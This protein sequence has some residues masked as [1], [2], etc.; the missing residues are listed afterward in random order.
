M[1]KNNNGMK[2]GTKSGLDWFKMLNEK[3]QKKF[4]DNA[5]EHERKENSKETKDWFNMLM[6]YPFVTFAAFIGSGFSL[7]DSKEGFAYW[8]SVIK[9]H[10]ENRGLN[11]FL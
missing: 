3:E 6:Q 1:S 9:R 7:K 5:N 2:A 10:E 11:D 8:N 4:K